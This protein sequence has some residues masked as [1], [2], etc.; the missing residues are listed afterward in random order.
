M[1]AI[2]PGTRPR[3]KK[4]PK[5]PTGYVVS[6]WGPA[7]RPSCM[8]EGVW[9]SVPGTPGREAAP[10]EGPELPLQEQDPARVSGQ[11]TPQQGARRAA[12]VIG[13]TD[14]RIR[15]TLTHKACHMSNTSL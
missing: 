10:A 1:Q 2:G 13:P 6:R 8:R 4:S 14:R 7:S 5:P 15:G 11:R 12:A 3:V 9:V